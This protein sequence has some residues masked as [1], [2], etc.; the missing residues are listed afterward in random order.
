[1]AQREIRAAYGSAA[2]RSPHA[3]DR[4]C[5]GRVVAASLRASPADATMGAPVAGT[6]DMTESTNAAVTT[7][8]L[9]A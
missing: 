2:K 7:A 4:A 5:P 9:F 1:M 8:A 3:Y 6:A